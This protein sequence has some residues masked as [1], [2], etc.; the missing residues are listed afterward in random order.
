M[1]CKK[2]MYHLIVRTAEQHILVFCRNLSYYCYP[3]PLLQVAKIAITQL[4]L[5]LSP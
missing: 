4:S 1:A 2:T 5:G 3:R